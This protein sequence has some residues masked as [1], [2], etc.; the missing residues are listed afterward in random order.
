MKIRI[1]DLR[2]QRGLTQAALAAKAGISRPFLAQIE[3]GD[4]NLSLKN[5]RKIAA[6]LGVNPSELVD[7][8]AEDSDEE[9]ILEAFSTLSGEQ[10]KVWVELARSVLRSSQDQSSD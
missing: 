1:A 9:I 10:R 6:S 5:Q 2:K 8:D 7:F 4:R 3:N